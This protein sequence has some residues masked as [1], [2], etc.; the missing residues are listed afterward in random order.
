MAVTQ[1]RPHVFSVDTG[2]SIAPERGYYCEVVPRS[3][4]VKSDFM[5]ANGI[6]II[7]PAYRG[8]ILVMLRYL[9]QE[10][11]GG[12]AQANALVGARVAQLLVRRL[13]VVE[14]KV[15]ESLEETPRGVG[16]F[17]SSGR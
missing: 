9:G 16:G 4:I 8:N 12:L 6:G 1:L 2:L 13:E 7:D 17:G 5:Q 11:D 14:I 15:E 10:P 3:S